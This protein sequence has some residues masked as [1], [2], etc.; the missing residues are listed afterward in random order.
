MALSVVFRL[1]DKH[2]FGGATG[3]NGVDQPA[4]ELLGAPNLVL[5]LLDAAAAPRG[6]AR[7]LLL[8]LVDLRLRA[9]Q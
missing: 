3:L 7:E 4:I 9:A 2:G 5:E 6:D 1:F 8:R